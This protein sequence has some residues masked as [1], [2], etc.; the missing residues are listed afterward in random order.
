MDGHTYVCGLGPVGSPRN[1]HVTPVGMPLGSASCHDGSSVGASTLPLSR[2]V[3]EAPAQLE[4]LRCEAALG[5]VQLQ[6]A[7]TSSVPDRLD[8]LAG[9]RPS[10][11]E[12]LN[13]AVQRSAKASLAPSATNAAA[14]DRRIQV[15]TRGR[16][17]TRSRIEAANIP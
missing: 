10:V 1:G 9:M 15:N 8:P 2:L 12:W 3:V 7:C 5:L 4:S 17:T 16:E 14:K 11:P 13:L 6:I